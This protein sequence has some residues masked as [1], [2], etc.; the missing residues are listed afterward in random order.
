MKKDGALPWT[1]LN[2]LIPYT[3]ECVKNEPSL[4][5]ISPVVL[6]KRI[7]KFR[8]YIFTLL[9]LSSLG[10]ECC[11]WTNLNPLHPRM[12]CTKFVW[13]LPSGSREKEKMWSLRQRRRQL[14]NC[15][16]KSSLMSLAQMS[17]NIKKKYLK[18]IT[19]TIS[20]FF[21]FY[22][23]QLQMCVCVCVCVCACVNL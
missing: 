7:F 20:F 5:K 11:P 17:P 18:K 15:D 13:N 22:N 6:E 2:Y 9:I 1:N 23:I 19:W 14:T 10:K 12:L 8:Q 16:Q 21:F 3:Q 4:V